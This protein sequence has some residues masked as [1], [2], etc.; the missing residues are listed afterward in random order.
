ME[1]HAEIYG[2]VTDIVTV[3]QRFCSHKNLSTLTFRDN[4][5]IR[6]R[7]HCVDISL[8][9]MPATHSYIKY[10]GPYL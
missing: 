9:R 4:I 10:C 6:T 1:N 7:L 5:I 8:T 2:H 3:C